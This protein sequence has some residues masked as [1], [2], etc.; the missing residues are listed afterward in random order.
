MKLIRTRLVVV[1]LVLLA[2]PA[3]TTQAQQTAAAPLRPPDVIFV[4]TPPKVVQA[5]L[6]VAKVEPNDI[7]YDLSSGDGRIPIAAVKEFGAT[8]ATGIDIDPQRIKEA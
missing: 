5:M 3:A 7:V 2:M 1:A 6:K 4:P 8:Q